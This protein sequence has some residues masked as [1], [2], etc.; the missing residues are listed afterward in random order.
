MNHS[1]LILAILA[2][3]LVVGVWYSQRPAKRHSSPPSGDIVLFRAVVDRMR[4]GESYYA[5]MN[6]ELRTRSYP[7]ASVVNWRL[8]GTFLLVAEAPRA[9]HF[10]MLTLG[11]IG[12]AL[13]VLLF[14]NAPPAVTIAAAI[15]QLGAA[16]VPAIPTDGLYMT[17]T[18]AGILLLLS[19]LAYTFG[20]VRLAVCCAVAAACAR[21][22]AVPY[23][24]AA[25]A[26]ALHARRMT[27]VRWYL[28]G[29][30]V[31]V[32]YYVTHAL[33]T[34]RYILA[35]DYGYPTWVTF[36]GWP[37]VLST[38]NMGGWF[39]LL[40]L[41]AAAIGAVIILAS[42]W[43]CADLHLKVVVGIYM[44]AFCFVGH[45]FNGYWGLMTGP[46][47]GLAAVYGLTGLHR[48]VSLA[49]APQPPTMLM[50]KPSG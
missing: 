20:A 45:S 38:V 34:S 29:F 36:N 18:W 25:L 15:I 5:A 7:T 48:L 47:W 32:A 11:A 41:W 35:G 6:A 23:A 8:P 26:L 10:V 22:I 44:L 12:L 19:V 24:I 33:F 27:E 39:L 49:V 42:L 31:F 3:L 30:G 50:R 37:F 28:I 2:G 17:E 1:R 14:R 43:S 40:P 13:S 21:E 46:I 9:A 16:L 4:A